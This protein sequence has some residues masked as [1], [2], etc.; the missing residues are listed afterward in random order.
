MCLERDVNEDPLKRADVDIVCYKGVEIPYERW[1]KAKTWL[2]RK[3]KRFKEYRTYFS[4]DSI[5]LGEIFV[6]QPVFNEEQ[7][8]TIDINSSFLEKGFIH[9]FKYKDAAIRFADRSLY[10]DVVECIIPAGT[11][12]F[13]G[14]NSDGTYGYA[15]TQLKY[16]K[17]IH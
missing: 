10:V 4:G 8:H 9:S 12:Y 16:V 6:A 7:L 17:V 2:L 15:S 14:I 3:L 1:F 11:Y 13:E 5:T